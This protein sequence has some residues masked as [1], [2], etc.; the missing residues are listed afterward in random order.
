MTLD[1]LRKFISDT[2]RHE[3]VSWYL[4]DDSPLNQLGL[5]YTLTVFDDAGQLLE[6]IPFIEERLGHQVPEEQI[7][8]IWSAREKAGINPGFVR[9]FRP[10]A[11]ETPKSHFE[12][13]RRRWLAT[14]PQRTLRRLI[15]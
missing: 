11:G 8:R 9:N 14:G 13:C 6:Q 4:R 2:R 12:A 7:A 15:S 10:A 1:E 5:M 3:G